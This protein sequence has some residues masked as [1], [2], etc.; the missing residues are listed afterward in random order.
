MT[1]RNSRKKVFNLRKKIFKEKWIATYENLKAIKVRNI[2][3]FGTNYRLKK[4]QRLSSGYGF[5]L[6]KRTF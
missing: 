1:N 4:K 3:P 2:F 5:C 6:I